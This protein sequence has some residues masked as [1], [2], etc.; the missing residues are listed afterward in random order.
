[1]GP[2]PKRKLVAPSGS[3]WQADLEEQRSI[4]SS[5][6]RRVRAA[7][8]NYQEKSDDMKVEIK[9]L[10]LL[11]GQEEAEVCPKLHL[12]HA[13]RRG[14]RIFVIFSTKEEDCHLVA[15]RNRWLENQGKSVALQERWRGDWQDID[16]EGIMTKA[17]PCTQRRTKTPMPQ[18]S[19]SSKM[20]EECQRRKRC[21]AFEKA[22][23]KKLRCLAGSEDL[24]VGL[25]ELR[26]EKGQK[27]FARRQ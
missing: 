6:E 9:A 11:M 1:M 15:S 26:N 10:E 5:Q 27:L 17:P 2:T 23:K 3:L 24:K 7:M 14:S 22:A 21:V 13:E 12:T 8:E 25:G 19:S 20:E 4:W 18:Q 16:C